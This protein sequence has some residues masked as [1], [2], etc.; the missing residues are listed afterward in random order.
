MMDNKPVLTLYNSLTRKK[1]AFT[2]MDAKKVTMY[3]CG[4]TVYSYAH[5][6]NARAAVVADVLFRVLRYIYGENHVEYARNITDIDDKIIKASQELGV[7]MEELTE[8]YA[9]IYNEDLAAI[10]CL[11]PTYQPKA[12]DN[13][14]EMVKLIEDLLDKEIAYIS[15][16]HVLFDVTKDKD[17]GKLSGRKLDDNRAG[18]RVEVASYK[19]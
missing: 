2:P 8:K 12:T 15:E 18:A 16:G 13:I 19:K 10:G 9:R 11:T 5:I 1:E 4:P 7:P 6:G 17:Y 3:C 14:K